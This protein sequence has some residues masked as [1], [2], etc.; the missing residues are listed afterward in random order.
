M[1]DSEY[2]AEN[3]S[4]NIFLLM[5]L[6]NDRSISHSIELNGL[7]IDVSN[8]PLTSAFNCR[9]MLM[10]RSKSFFNEITAKQKILIKL[11]FLC[12]HPSVIMFSSASSSSFNDECISNTTVII[13]FIL[14]PSP[15][16]FLL[17]LTNGVPIITCTFVIKSK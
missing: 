17:T 3:S 13:L 11:T 8:S 7:F 6:R 5:I 1:N 2:C 14:T 10:M 15:S 4:T 12:L 9:K 16:F